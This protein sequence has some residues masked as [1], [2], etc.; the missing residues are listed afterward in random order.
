MDET[1]AIASPDKILKRS[2]YRQAS[3]VF[4]FSLRS[5]ETGSNTNWT[6]NCQNLENF[7]NFYTSLNTI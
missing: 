5:F 4:D 7:N 1:I 3:F 2:G 6:R